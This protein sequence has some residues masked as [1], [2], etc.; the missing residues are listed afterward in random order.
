MPYDK[1]ATASYFLLLVKLIPPFKAISILVL[2]IIFSKY[3]H[4]HVLA[5]LK[6]SVTGLAILV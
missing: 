5:D 4:I 6:Y 3:I 2:R 1:L